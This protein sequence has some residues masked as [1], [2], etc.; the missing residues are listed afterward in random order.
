MMEVLSGHINRASSLSA[1]GGGFEIE[2]FFRM[3][4]KARLR[5]LKSLMVH[6]YSGSPRGRSLN[7]INLLLPPSLHS[8]DTNLPLDA[9]NTAT[10]H[11]ASLTCFTGPFSGSRAF[12]R[13]VA[14]ASNLARLQISCIGDAEGSDPRT[15]L[16]HENLT[17][18]T[19]SPSCSMSIAL[20]QVTLPRLERLTIDQDDETH[21]T[22]PLQR[23]QNWEAVFNRLLDR[24]QCNLKDFV[25]TSLL[26][27]QAL[28]PIWCMASLIS[29]SLFLDS[30]MLHRDYTATVLDTLTVTPSQQ[31]LPRLRQNLQT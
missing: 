11:W 24:S 1:Y 29:L 13:F 19:L 23:R 26:P 22:C 2:G 30:P 31:H 8:I 14:E 6:R 28:T 3:L 15:L 4:A 25:A 12:L 20:D 21:S 5:I 10:V 9:F 17:D 27:L 16:V 7:T 18:L